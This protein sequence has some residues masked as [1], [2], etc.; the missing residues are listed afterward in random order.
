[1]AK[2]KV[3]R[4]TSLDP[5]NAAIFAE[6]SRLKSALRREREI[7]DRLLQASSE[8]VVT[9]TRGRVTAANPAA[10]KLLGRRRAGELTGER[11]LDSVHLR[12]RPAIKEGVAQVLSDGSVITI[13]GERMVGGDGRVIEVAIEVMAITHEERPATQLLI[14]NLS[15]QQQTRRYLDN[16][17]ILFES[18]N[19]FASTLNKGEIMRLIIRQVRK[20]VPEAAECYIG[21][22]KGD[23]LMLRAFYGL[24]KPAGRLMSVNEGVVGWVIRRGRH[25]LIKRASLDPLVMAVPGRT[26]HLEQLLCLPL[27]VGEEVIGVISV[28]LTEGDFDD[29]LVKTLLIL[30]SRAAVAI[31]HALTFEQALK[32]RHR[33]EAVVHHS[34]EGIS[35]IDRTGR[36]L[37]W[38]PALERIT[39]YSVAEVLGRTLSDIFSVDELGNIARLEKGGEFETPIATRSGQERWV[40]ITSS[41]VREEW[42]SEQPIRNII[43]MVRD[44]TRLKE[45]ETKKS[46][47]VSIASHELRTPL[48]AIKGY[49]SMLLQEDAGELNEQQLKFL[50]RIYRSTDRLVNLV[51]DVLSVSRIE[52]NRLATRPR[53]VDIAEVLD[54]LIH[55]LDYRA[56][57]KSVTIQISPASLPPVLADPGHLRQVLFNLIDNAI[58]YTPAQGG[59]SVSFQRRKGYL[60]TQ[61]SDTGVGIAEDQLPKLFEKFERVNNPL[62][63]RAGGSGLGLF[64]TKSL[65][66]RQG[67]K[68]WVKSVP[69]EGSV[70]SFS[71]PIYQEDLRLFKVS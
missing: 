43:V 67:G 48:T 64:I 46:E 30:T 15:E 18:S 8:A 25:R 28:G 61:I 41:V 59:V 42:M 71:L 11:F 68:I 23:D 33:W 14:R 13:E 65:I 44:I 56:Q 50:D 4:P 49:L 70:F 38:N 34:G 52:E 16:L 36:I 60:I 32:E 24:E 29:E 54:G 37:Y 66:E 22:V 19:L 17:E 62:S 51:E 31:D 27:Q 26:K 1:M 9:V 5:A 3:T 12:S 2:A 10:A 7:Y 6:L 53:A 40:S 47:F 20:L 69:K 55:E 35:T 57:E 58:K 21:L 63:I 39:G 45:I